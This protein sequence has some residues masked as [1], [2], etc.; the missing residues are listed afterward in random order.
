MGGVTQNAPGAAGGG[1]GVGGFN[2][3]P[4]GPISTQLQDLYVTESA[5]S[6][7][8]TKLAIS[9]RLASLGGYAPVSA[10][11]ITAQLLNNSE[12]RLAGNILQSNVNLVDGQYI[13][14]GVES[15]D[16][17]NRTVMQ[18]EMLHIAQYLRNPGITT[19]GIIG[20]FHEIVPSFVGTPEIY[21]GGTAI[22]IGG[23]GTVYYFTK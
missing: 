2:S 4:T 23:V 3:L 21:G 16:Y 14:G 11:E 10:E 1:F 9:N 18:H 13:I 17:L 20:G 15:A 19:T 7:F 8:R 5:S 22:V 12:F 6:M